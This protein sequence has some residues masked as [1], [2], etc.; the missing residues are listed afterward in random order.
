M[1]IEYTLV[2]QQIAG[3]SAVPAHKLSGYL[4]KSTTL[5]P[6]RQV[7]KVVLEITQLPTSVGNNKTPLCHC[8][9]IPTLESQRC[10]SCGC[11]SSSAGHYSSLTVLYPY[12]D[13]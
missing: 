2:Q 7:T 13:S 6:L 11:I 3:S 12:Y 1:P 8:L 4:V 10:L 9:L 5:A